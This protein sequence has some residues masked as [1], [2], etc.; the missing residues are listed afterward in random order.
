MAYR[1]EYDPE[2]RLDLRFHVRE[3]TWILDR[4][5]A[6]LRHE[7]TKEDRNRKPTRAGAPGPWE[8]RVIP[9]RVFYAVDTAAQVVRVL[10]VYKKER[11]VWQRR[12]KTEE[13]DAETESNWAE[14]ATEDGVSG[15]PRH[16]CGCTGRR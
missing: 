16:S 1:I 4:I 15:G 5:E 9:F 2:A 7:P 8:L 10:S 11:D 6:R 13:F 3:A 14:G 12:G